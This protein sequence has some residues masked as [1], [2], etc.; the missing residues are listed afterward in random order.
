MYSG[1]DNWTKIVGATLALITFAWSVWTRRDG[2]MREQSDRKAALDQSMRELRWRQTVEAQATIRRMTEDKH[3][4][5]AMTIL[6]W[7]GRRFEIRSGTRAKITWKLMREALR[8][9]PAIFTPEEV[10]V[11]D[12]FDGL[13]DKFEMMEHQIA[14]GLFCDKDVS[15]P[16]EY[17]ASR[18]KHPS[19]WPIFLRYLNTYKY[20]G[21][22]RLIERMGVLDPKVDDDIEAASVFDERNT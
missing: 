10:F 1:I 7:N 14:N 17:Y 5:D 20:P 19:N 6:D 4:N 3:A 15:Y 8:L 9:E 11:R 21:A 18:M 13:F 2:I 12:A 16:M 22:L